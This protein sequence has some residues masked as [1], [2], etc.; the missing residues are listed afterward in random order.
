MN[1]QCFTGHEVCVLTAHL[2]HC[3]RK[4]SLM[5]TKEYRW[6]PGNFI[7]RGWQWGQLG[8]WT[9]VCFFLDM[10]KL[11]TPDLWFLEERPLESWVWCCIPLIPVTERQGDRLISVFEATLLY[12]VSSRLGRATRWN[13][14]RKNEKRMLLTQ[15]EGRRQ[16]RGERITSPGGTDSISRPC[17]WWDLL[18]RAKD[19]F[20]HPDYRL[21]SPSSH[22]S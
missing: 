19:L 1:S 22:G 18:T 17:S 12:T 9:I 10:E 3:G 7:N 11:G 8:F 20:L 2:S 21:I 15:E 5:Y 16:P 6:V 4:R 13:P 14:E